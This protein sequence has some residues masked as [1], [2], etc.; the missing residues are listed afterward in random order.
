MEV[1][2]LQ[3]LE[4]NPCQDGHA[5]GHNEILECFSMGSV[6]TLVQLAHLMPPGTLL[7]MCHG[8]IWPGS[9]AELNEVE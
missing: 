6:C 9:L 2:C 5:T 1:A 4:L 7:V 3:L 8:T